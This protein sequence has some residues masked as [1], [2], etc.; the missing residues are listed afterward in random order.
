M[1]PLG[2]WHDKVVTAVLRLDSKTYI[3]VVGGL[4][5]DRTSGQK[6]E[7]RKR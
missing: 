3:K 6:R 5:T 2:S 4:E 1:Q 7:P